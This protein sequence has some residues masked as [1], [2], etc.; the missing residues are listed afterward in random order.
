MTKTTIDLLGVQLLLG[1][2]LLTGACFS[3]REATGPEDTSPCD[4]TTTACAVNVTDNAFSPGTRRVTVGSTV[5]WTNNGASPHTS[6]GST[7]DSGTILVG[8]SFEHTFET[9]D[10]YSYDCEFHPG[11]TGTIIV[12]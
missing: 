10:T 4:G 11:M 1:A 2:T 12:E 6:T 3:E 9:A 7:W 8:G 5:R